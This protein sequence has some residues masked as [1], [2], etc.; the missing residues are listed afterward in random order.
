MDLPDIFRGMEIY[1]YEKWKPYVK[2]H[3]FDDNRLFTKTKPIL[4]EMMRPLKNESYKN[5]FSEHF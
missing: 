2:L 1:N 5:S 4:I 3:R